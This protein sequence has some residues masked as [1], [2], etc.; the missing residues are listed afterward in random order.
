[1]K[2]PSRCPDYLAT[3]AQNVQ[4]WISYRSWASA[5]T[6]MMIYEDV[7]IPSSQENQDHDGFFT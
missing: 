7:F 2:A 6:P 4:D 3:F 1:M 5:M